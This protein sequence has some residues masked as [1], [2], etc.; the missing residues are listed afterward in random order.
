LTPAVTE[1]KIWY[2]KVDGLSNI[3]GST[4]KRILRRI[5]VWS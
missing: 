3:E 1:P 5:W 4:L 2:L